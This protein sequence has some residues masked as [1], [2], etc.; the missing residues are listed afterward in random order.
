MSWASCLYEGDVVHSRLEPVRHDLRVPV[1]MLYADLDELPELFSGS[2]LWANEARAAVSFRRADHL[3]DPAR[4]LA[5]CVRELVDSRV[6]SRPEGP[7]RVLT[8]P[9]YLGFVLNPASVYYCFDA[10]GRSLH[11]L[12]CEVTNTP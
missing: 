8:N 3:G 1:Q 2:R 10:D 9:R 12:V 5:Q 6:G 4:P 11:S 7:I